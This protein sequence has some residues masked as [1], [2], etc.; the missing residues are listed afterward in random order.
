[1]EVNFDHAIE[2]LGESVCMKHFNPLPERVVTSLSAQMSQGTSCPLHS[3]F[4]NRGMLL[5]PRPKEVKQPPG[6]PP[7]SWSTDPMTNGAPDAR[8]TLPARAR[9]ETVKNNARNNPNNAETRRNIGGD[10]SRQSRLPAFTQFNWTIKRRANR[11][12]LDIGT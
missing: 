6:V 12:M 11:A 7:P 1:M 4:T 8:F 10:V 5:P 2:S 9:E 3:V